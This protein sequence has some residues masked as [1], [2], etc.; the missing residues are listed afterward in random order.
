MK[1]ST[2]IDGYLAA[3]PS[4]QAE[5]LGRLRERICQLVPEATE[6]MSYNM[7]MFFFNGMLVGYLARKNGL[8]LQL[9]SRAVGE[10]MRAELASRGF[11]LGGV[12]ALH[13]SEDQEISDD[14]LA[15]ILTLRTAENAARVA[16]RKSPSLEG[17][18]A[19]QS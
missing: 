7:P 15:R 19:P 16:K 3:L 2:E 14:L 10:Q 17:R 8:S 5:A 9:C 6:Q 4:G 18:K 1:S 12:G 13:F 11:H